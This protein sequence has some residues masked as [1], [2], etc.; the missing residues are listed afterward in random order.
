[1]SNQYV[2]ASSIG[3]WRSRAATGEL[4][5]H[6][7]M[8]M[9]RPVSVRLSRQF[10]VSAARLFDAWLEPGWL[11]AFLSGG[12]LVRACIGEYLEIDRPQRLVFT[13][14]GTGDDDSPD[15]VTIELAPLGRACLLVLLHEMGLHRTPDRARIQRAWNSALDQLIC[16]ACPVI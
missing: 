4:Q 11:S 6:L 13:L 10:S 14:T 3:A 9:I 16:P 7:A 1:M 15:Y 12:A 5:D 8:S 2:D